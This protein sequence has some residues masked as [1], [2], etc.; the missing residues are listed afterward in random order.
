M[1]EAMS[2]I[3]FDFHPD[4]DV[5]DL[6]A[7]FVFPL[8]RLLISGA[9]SQHVYAIQAKAKEVSKRTG[10]VYGVQVQPAGVAVHVTDFAGGVA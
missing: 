2:T 6:I 7:R 10:Y 8:G 4:L 3:E 9:T 1:T 5:A